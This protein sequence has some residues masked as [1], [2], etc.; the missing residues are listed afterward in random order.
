MTAML[1]PFGTSAYW[2]ERA[3]ETRT[4]ALQMREPETKRAMLAV[5]ENYEKMAMKAETRKLGFSPRPREI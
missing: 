4:I 3:H 5:A 2:I 1:A